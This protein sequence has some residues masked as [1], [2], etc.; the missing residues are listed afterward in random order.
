MKYIACKS[1]YSIVCGNM[2]TKITYLDT[3]MWYG[4]GMSYYKR[5]ARIFDS[6]EEI[7]AVIIKARNNNRS[8]FDVYGES[9]YENEFWVIEPLTEKEVFVQRLTQ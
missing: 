2:Q 9:D 8:D 6:K 5:N 4:L 7:K 3:V 1:C